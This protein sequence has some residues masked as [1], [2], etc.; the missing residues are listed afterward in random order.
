MKGKVK[1][2]ITLLMITV[3]VVAL[4]TVVFATGQINPGDVTPV[5]DTDMG[6][7]QS[8]ARSIMGVIRNIAVLLAVIIIAI[9]GVKFILGSAEEKAEYKKSFIPLIVGIIVVVAAT[10]IAVFIFDIVG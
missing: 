1:I 3:L 10:Q 2:V 4:G 9:I 8:T 6:D 5:F 7:I